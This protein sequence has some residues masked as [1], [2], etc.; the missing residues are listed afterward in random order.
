MGIVLNGYSYIT[1]SLFEEEIIVEEKMKL[2]L[3]ILLTIGVYI[4]Q[5]K[6]DGLQC[7]VCTGNCLENEKG[8]L[9]DCA[10]ND[11]FCAKAEQEVLGLT[12]VKRTCSLDSGFNIPIEEGCIEK[13]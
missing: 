5:V 10:A 4:A 3:I 7:W 6:T 2:T 12:V 8:E 9:T 13:T 1:Y 11:K